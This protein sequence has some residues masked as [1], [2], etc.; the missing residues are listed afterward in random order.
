MTLRLTEQ[1][2]KRMT[3]KNLPP[4]ERKIEKRIDKL[5]KELEVWSKSI[6]GLI[7]RLIILEVKTGIPLAKERK[8]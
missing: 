6:Q 2:L 7:K 8:P 3:Q 1:Q 5:E 4:D